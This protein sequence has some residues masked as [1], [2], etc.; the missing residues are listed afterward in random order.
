M[1][2]Q[3]QDSGMLMFQTLCKIVG[4]SGDVHWSLRALVQAWVCGV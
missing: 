3:A 1:F 2:E 4:I